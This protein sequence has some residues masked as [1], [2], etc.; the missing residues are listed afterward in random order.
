LTFCPLVC[1]ADPPLRHKLFRSLQSIQSDLMITP[2]VTVPP[3]NATNSS[4]TFSTLTY[5]AGNSSLLSLSTLIALAP[6]EVGGDLILSDSLISITSSGALQVDGSLDLDNSSTLELVYD[7]FSTESP[8]QIK[9]NCGFGGNSEYTFTML[10]TAR[11]LCWLTA[12]RSLVHSLKRLSPLAHQNRI[13][14]HI[15]LPRNL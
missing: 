11:H 3:L 5:I 1:T 2:A 12:P 7:P 9:G 8:L 6:V 10:P 13:V 4:F 14:L 15:Q